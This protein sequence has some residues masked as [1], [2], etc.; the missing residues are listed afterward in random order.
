MNVS[1]DIWG[2]VNVPS[3]HGLR[4]CLLVID[5][6]TN[7]MRVRFHKAKDDNCNELESI[8]FEVRHLHARYHSAEGAFA[9]VLTF[10]SYSVFEAIATRQ[11][12]GR[13]GVGF[14]FSVPYAHHML[15]KAEHP[16]RT[17]RDNAYAMMHIMLVLNAM[18]SC[19]VNTIVFLR[20]R[21]FSRVVGLSGGVP[22]TLLTQVEPD[23]S[24]FRV[25]GWAVFAEVP[26]KLRRKFGE[27]AVRGVMV[28]YPPDARGYHVYNPVTRRIS[29][30]VHVMFQETVPGFLPSPDID[31]LIFDET[32]IVS[33]DA[34]F[35]SSHTISPYLVD[36][37]DGPPLHEDTRQSRIRS[38]PVRF[39]EYVAHLSVFPP[40][41][42]TA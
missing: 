7:Y 22:L 37:D 23:A 29:A 27:K 41:Y 6:H 11:M 38:H 18:W 40:V 1:S 34:M 31:S 4:Y 17:I 24:K 13:L 2:P 8:V 12:C 15:G 14:Q 42:V 19:A 25:F 32:E 33:G 5:H 10:D 39:G 20:N 21:T 30:S 28:G 9:P 26:D 3:P 16:W 36:N 35:P